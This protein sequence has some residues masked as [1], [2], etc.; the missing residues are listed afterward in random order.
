M[1]DTKINKFSDSELKIQVDGNIGEEV[2]LFQS[3]S[4][5]VNDH[6]MELLLLADTAKR[7][8]ASKIIAVIPYFGYGRQDRCTY[9][10][11]PISASLVAKMIEAA[12]ITK[13]ITLD[14]HSNQLEGFF[15]IPVVN[16]V[17]E[18]IFF[19]VIQKQENTIVVSPDLGGISRARSYSLLLG[20]Q[21][22]IVNKS[23]DLNNICSTN[24]IMGD[25]KGKHCVIVDD[26]IDG[27]NTICL[28]TDLL[29]EKGA[30]SVEAIVTHGVLSGDAIKKVENSGLKNLYVADSIPITELTDKLTVLPAH[31]LFAA[32]LKQHAGTVI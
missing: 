18:S 24:G 25:V 12:G 8:G 29:F 17:A 16:L 31:E 22:A 21:M 3:T 9:K 19:P 6:L 5:P 32:A 2:I 14:L 27:A 15:N 13:I 30:S 26:I 20:V 7:A 4:A 10:N 28:A 23:R 11:G 1:L